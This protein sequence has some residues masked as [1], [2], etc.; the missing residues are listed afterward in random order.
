MERACYTDVCKDVK[1]HM[2]HDMILGQNVICRYPGK[3][4]YSFDIAQQVHFPSV[5]LQPGPI[6]F[7]CPRKCVLLG[8]AC[9][10]FPRQVN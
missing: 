9:E 2:P 5:P 8:I 10:A 1:D 7:K 4:H 6:Y 3:C